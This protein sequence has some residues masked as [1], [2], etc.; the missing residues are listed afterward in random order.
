[1]VVSE[2]RRQDIER[3]YAEFNRRDIEAVLARM[4]D[5]VHWANGMEGG[6]VDGRDAVREYWLRQFEVIDG[7]VEPERIVGRDQDRVAVHVHQVVHSPSGELLADEHVTH[8]FTFQGG[9]IA[10]FD[11]EAV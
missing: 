8:V 7:R 1:V 6:Y 3:L 2:D 10:R 5:D 4:T 11:I 9:Q